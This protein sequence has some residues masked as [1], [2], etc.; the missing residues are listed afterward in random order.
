MF[1][2]EIDFQDGISPPELLLVR[3][4]SMIIGSGEHAQ[5]VIDGVG[6]TELRVS[7][8][9]GR[10]FSCK[11][12]SRS[13][14]QMSPSFIEGSYSGSAELQLRDVSLTITALDS[15]LLVR[16]GEGFDI[17][18]LRLL[19]ESL[20][21][22]IPVFPALCVLG[23]MPVFASFH[24]GQPIQIGRSRACALRVESS[25]VS[26]IHARVGAE[27][28][29]F[30]IEDLGSTNGTYVN[31]QRVS[32]RVVLNPGELFRIGA[33][34]NI[35]G[36][37]KPEDLPE[38]N[39]R[40][41]TS[42][43]GQAPGRQY[44]V[45]ISKSP[46]VKPARYVLIQGGE[47]FVGRDPSNDVWIGASHISRKH[48]SIKMSGD[49]RVC[50]TDQ[51][52]NGTKLHRNIMPRGQA[53][54]LDRDENHLDLGEGIEFYLCFTKES[55]AKYGDLDNINHTSL[56][57]QEKNRKTDLDSTRIGDFS[58]SVGDDAFDNLVFKD[59][60]NESV[61][62]T[63]LSVDNQV[64]AEISDELDY[65]KEIYGDFDSDYNRLRSSWIVRVLVLVSLF[66]L[67]G[68]L[69]ILGNLIL[70]V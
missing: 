57:V 2:L 27:E 45:L 42:N 10:E 59:S 64:L 65:D 5:V 41:N 48:L 37:Y 69:F 17:E 44:P 25:E 43:I 49:G 54:Y 6:A 51:S 61:N 60:D 12:L 53:L 52:S 9:I 46:L 3:R 16:E 4:S 38:V 26:A 31:G 24:E 23:S 14:V 50:V 13:E 47:S 55:A 8:G 70:G 35:V 15:D 56:K 30:W 62:K 40:R 33:D 36:V 29:R 20:S 18:G 58:G 7:R 67:I 22:S 28:G 39:K 63:S 1:A 34:L 32:G 21:R 19:R 66:G 68:L 11:S